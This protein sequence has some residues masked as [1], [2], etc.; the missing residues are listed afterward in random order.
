MSKEQASRTETKILEWQGKS[1]VHGPERKLPGSASFYRNGD[2]SLKDNES[3]AEFYTRN[4]LWKESE[5][6]NCRPV[7]RGGRS[8]TDRC[9]RK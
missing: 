6:M 2:D 4:F 8:M 1:A 7:C 9:P 3:T 5:S